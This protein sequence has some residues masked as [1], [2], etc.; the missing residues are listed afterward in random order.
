MVRPVEFYL[1]EYHEPSEPPSVL[2]VPEP[3]SH[4][5]TSYIHSASLL[6]KAVSM[7]PIT[8]LVAVVVVVVATGR[9][10]TDRSGCDLLPS[11]EYGP[12][13]PPS[14]PSS[15]S[16]HPLVSIPITGTVWSPSWEEFRS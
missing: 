13:S 14:T 10:D 8:L 15:H 9:L 11:L 1:R 16:R 12:T 4:S 5:R 2:R 7:D 6:G 3:T